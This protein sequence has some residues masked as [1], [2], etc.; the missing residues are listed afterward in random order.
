MEAQTDKF[1]S[2]GIVYTPT[3]SLFG[4]WFLFDQNVYHIW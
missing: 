1:L 4:R 2:A 3:M